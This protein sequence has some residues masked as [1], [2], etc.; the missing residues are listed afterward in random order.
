MNL[1]TLDLSA[2]KLAT[3]ADIF[4]LMVTFEKH[5]FSDSLQ[6]I[7]LKIFLKWLECVPK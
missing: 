6:C 2:K 3:G 4:P 1:G 5:I 7:S